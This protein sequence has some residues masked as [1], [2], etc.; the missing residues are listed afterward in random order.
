MRELL[1]LFRENGDFRNEV[2]NTTREVLSTK[3]ELDKKKLW[4]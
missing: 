1:E 2:E 3:I 4:T